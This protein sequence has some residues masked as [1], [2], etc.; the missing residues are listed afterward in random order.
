MVVTQHQHQLRTKC[1]EKCVE[2]IL[3]Q[4]NVDFVK[5][6]SNFPDAGKIKNGAGLEMDSFAKGVEKIFNIKSGDWQVMIGN[7]I[8]RSGD[9]NSL[10]IRK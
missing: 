4:E 9:R 3:P 1:H 6:I 8:L 7:T 5:Q 10:L 2:K